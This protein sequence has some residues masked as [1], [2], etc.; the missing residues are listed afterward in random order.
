MRPLTGHTWQTFSRAWEVDVQQVFHWTREALLRP[1]DP[2]STVVALSSNAAL[3]GS[4]LSGGYAGAKATIRFICAYAA[5]ESARNQLGV[6]FTAVLPKLTPA[7][8]LGADAVAAYA[9]LEGI[10]VPAFLARMGPPLTPEQA[11][12]TVADLT[13]RPGADHPAYLLTA[14][15]LQP[16]GDEIIS[17]KPDS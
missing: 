3:R 10:D 12:T 11:G 2:G 1:L 5:G 16:V 17:G 6:T 7:T 4:P 8:D 15:G 9:A 14:E 13:G